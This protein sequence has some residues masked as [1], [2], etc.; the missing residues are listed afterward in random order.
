MSHDITIRVKAQVLDKNNKEK[1]VE[2]FKTSQ[3]GSSI[4]VDNKKFPMQSPTLQ[5][6][7]NLDNAIRNNSN[8]TPK[9]RGIHGTPAIDQTIGVVVG[10]GT[11]AVATSDIALQNNI[12]HNASAL[13][14]GNNEI[15]PQGTATLNGETWT[16]KSTNGRARQNKTGIQIDTITNVSGNTWRYTLNS[17]QPDVSSAVVGEDVIFTDAT[18]SANNG[19]FVVT[20]KTAT[21][22]DIVNAGGIAESSSPCVATVRIDAWSARNGSFAIVMNNKIYLIGGY[23]DTN[24]LNDVWSSTDGITWTEILTDTGS[25][26]ANQFSQRSYFGCIVYDEKIW[27]IGGDGNSSNRLNDVWSSTDG[28]TWTEVLANNATPPTTQFDR[29]HSHGLLVFDNKMWVIGGWATNTSVYYANDVWSSTDGITWT[30]VTSSASFLGKRIIQQCCVFDNKMWVL[31]GWNTSSPLSEIHSSTDGITW[32]SITGTGDWYARGFGSVYIFDNKMWIIHGDEGSGNKIG[33]LSSTDGATWTEITTSGI[34]AMR[35][36]AGSIIFDNK[37][38]YCGGFTDSSARSGKVW[39]SEETITTGIQ[40]KFVN[41]SGSNIDIEE[42]GL[43][44]GIASNGSGALVCVRDLLSTTVRPYYAQN[45]QYKINGL[46]SSTLT[47][48]KNFFRALEGGLSNTNKILRDVT[49]TDRSINPF[50]I[51]NGM[52]CQGGVSDIT[53]GLVIGTGTT[54]NWEDHSLIVI[55]DSVCNIKAQS[56]TTPYAAGGVSS[57]VFQRVFENISGGAI[58]IGGF[59]LYGYDGSNSFQLLSGTLNIAL[60]DG[61]SLKIILTLDATV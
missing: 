23:D 6:F 61:D 16:E 22:I 12:A 45:L 2:S 29:R 31:G 1:T 57:I 42:T 39:T 58:N 40:R 25:P 18:N 13:S 5:F 26:G 9:F 53:R 59:A 17:S 44:T 7:N 35:L 46:I 43:K 10:S 60:Q 8:D 19:T 41:N 50:S 52:D 49:G 15:I 4:N 38:W 21:T 48:N 14:F 24:R 3:A 51:S 54:I 55:P 56:Y 32:S 37:L 11:N 28:I 36:G 33:L 47:F 20:A 30:E 34:D 27:V